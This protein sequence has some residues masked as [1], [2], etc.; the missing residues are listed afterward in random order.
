MLIQNE[1][2]PSPLEWFPIVATVSFTQ[3]E[4]LSAL[5]FIYSL[6][7]FPNYP[8]INSPSSSP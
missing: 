3:A 4:S 2:S 6:I 8:Y 1:S 5:S 7:S